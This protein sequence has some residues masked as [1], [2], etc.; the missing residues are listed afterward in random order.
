MAAKTELGRMGNWRVLGDDSRQAWV[1]W[2]HNYPTVAD[3]LDDDARRPEITG[4]T[5]ASA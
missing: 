2:M 3:E 5:G 1:L 4:V